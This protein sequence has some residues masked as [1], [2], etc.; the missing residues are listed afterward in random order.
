MNWKLLAKKQLFLHKIMKKTVVSG[1]KPTVVAPISMNA[2][3]QW[4]PDELIAFEDGITGGFNASK[5]KEP[6]CKLLE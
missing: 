1:A 2:L 5:I 3:R 4:T 6:T